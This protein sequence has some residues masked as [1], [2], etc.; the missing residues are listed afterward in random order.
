MGVSTVTLYRWA[1]AGDFP[2]PYRIG[3]QAIAF[4][5]EEVAAWLETRRAQRP[6]TEAPDRLMA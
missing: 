4:D 5:S 1:K 6:E 2:Q 3:K